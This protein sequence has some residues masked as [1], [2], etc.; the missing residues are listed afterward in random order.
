MMKKGKFF[1]LIVLIFSYKLNANDLINYRVK[2]TTVGYYYDNELKTNSVKKNYTFDVSTDNNSLFGEWLED[3]HIYTVMDKSHPCHQRIPVYSLELSNSEDEIPDNLISYTKKG[4]VS[5][6]IPSYFIDILKDKNKEKIKEYGTIVPS[7]FSINNPSEK[8]SEDQNFFSLIT[9]VGICLYNDDE[10]DFVNIKAEPTLIVCEAVLHSG[11]ENEDYDYECFNWRVNIKKSTPQGHLEKIQLKIDGD[12]LKIY[13]LT[14]NEHII[15][16]VYVNDCVIEELINLFNTNTCDLSCVAWPRHADG[17]CDYDGSK[18]IA[19]TQTANS[20][21]S[22]NVEKNK[23]M[24][25]NENLK[26]RSG[27]ATST[28]VLTV[29]SA[30]TKVKILELGKAETIDGISSN[31]VKVEVQKGAKDRDGNPIKAGTV[32][33]CYGG[34]L[35]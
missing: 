20:T 23:T 25:V 6:V 9:K 31:W 16:L 12:Y 29:M 26:L 21:A 30:G 22:T 4:F 2:E 10:I 33:W 17:S 18:T 3:K 19:T 8:F 34:Y 15:T 13:N 28:Q 35:K 24:L 1:L 27:E 32:G 14:R 5:K 11:C 7:S